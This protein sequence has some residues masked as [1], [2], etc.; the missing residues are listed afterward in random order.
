[1]QVGKDLSVLSGLSEKQIRIAIDRYI[2][3]LATENIDRI[4]DNLLVDE[5]DEIFRTIREKS[6]HSEKSGLDDCLDDRSLR[7]SSV[8]EATKMVKD[9]VIGKENLETG[10]DQ[11]E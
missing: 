11:P 3:N 9:A 2:S 5:I 6:E 4:Y 10:K 8:Q 1:M 7:T